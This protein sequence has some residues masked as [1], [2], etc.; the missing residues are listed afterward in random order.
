MKSLM[1]P[2]CVALLV[3]AACKRPEDAE[4]VANKSQAATQPEATAPV[5]ADKPSDEAATPKPAVPTLQVTTVA[6]APYELSQH[7]GK[8]VV[9]NFWA[10]WCAPCLKEMPELSALDAMREH[11]EVVG[12]AYEEIEPADMRAFLEKHPVV[13][14]V[15][16]LDVYAPP[17]DFATPRGLPMT[18]LIAPDGKVAKQFLG[19]VTAKEIE[20]TI[21]KADGPATAA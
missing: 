11:V 14:P 1:L 20:D 2:L 12:L 9:V 19:P 6:G 7:R 15:A 8:W 10:T 3:L 5:A 13:Y 21:A 4:P 18:Y 17:A 16:I